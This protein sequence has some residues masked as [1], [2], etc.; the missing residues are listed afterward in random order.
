MRTLKGFL[1]RD[2]YISNVPDVV[3]DIF[4]LSDYA[5]TYAKDKKSF[6]YSQNSLYTLRVFQSTPSIGQEEAD[7]ISAFV[8]YFG[9]FATANPALNHDQLVINA[10]ASFNASNPT[11]QITQ[12]NFNSLITYR[13][14]RTAGYFY[15]IVNNEIEALVWASNTLFKTI[16]PDYIIDSVLPFPE[17]SVSV[18]NPSAFIG[19]LDN[20]NYTVFMDSVNVAKGGYPP[21][22]TRVLNIPY[23]VPNTTVYKNCYFGFNIYN[24]QGNYDDLLKLKLFDYLLANTLLTQPIIEQIFPSLLEINEFFIIPR[25]DNLAIETQVGQSAIFSQVNLSYSRPFDL[26][27]YIT[28][29]PQAHITSDTY[30]VP[31]QY[32]NILLNVVNGYYT[33]AGKKDFKANYS[34]LIT[35]STTDADFSRMSTKTQNFLTALYDLLYLVDSPSFVDMYNKIYTNNLVASHKVRVRNGI[36]YVSVH[37]LDHIYYI[38]PRYEFLR[39]QA[40][41]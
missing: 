4:E 16:Y 7:M 22:H 8:I 30:D 37:Y 28:I 2:D 13:D 9:E 41:V 21:T 36:S 12:L 14:I 17:F 18:S 31:T 15:F 5:S 39:L 26:L 23:K 6:H 35:V 38:L 29:Y 40:N 19:L 33:S 11:N 1:I 25:W 3:S 27:K 32:N 20:F 34:D 10:Q 24:E